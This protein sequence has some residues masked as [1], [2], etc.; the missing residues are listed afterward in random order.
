MH[1]RGMANIECIQPGIDAD[2]Q[3]AR[4][5]VGARARTP[6]V[7]VLFAGVAAALHLIDDNFIEAGRGPARQHLV[8]CLVPMAVVAGLGWLSCRGR[9]GARAVATLVLG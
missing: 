8:S 3:A 2:E 4:V 1:G 7:A 5:A 9:T 6:T